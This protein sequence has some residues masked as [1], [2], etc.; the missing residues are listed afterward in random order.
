LFVVCGILLLQPLES[1]AE[2][3]ASWWQRWFCLTPK[4]EF[5][6][7]NEWI[8]AWIKDGQMDRWMD[9]WMGGGQLLTEEYQQYCF[10]DRIGRPRQRKI[11]Y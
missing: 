4:T 1:K 2:L 6:S 5:L 10:G 3:K 9:G 8:H 7:M 11:N